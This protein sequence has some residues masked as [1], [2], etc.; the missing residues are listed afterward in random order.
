[1]IIGKSGSGK[2]F[3]LKSLLLNEWANGTRV[4]VLDPEAEYLTL[5]RNL[6]GN[7]GKKK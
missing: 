4:V 7:N 2:S 5:T 3:F 6:H 1:M